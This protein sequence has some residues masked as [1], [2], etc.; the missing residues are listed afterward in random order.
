MRGRAEEPNDEAY[1]EDA[2][3]FINRLGI[4]K[5]SWLVPVIDNYEISRMHGM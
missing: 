3:F 2:C 5:L 4:D 1:S